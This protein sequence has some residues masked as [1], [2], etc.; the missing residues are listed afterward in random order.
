VFAKEIDL[1]MKSSAA[2]LV[3]VFCVAAISLQAQTPPPATQEPD[4]EVLRAA[5]AN[6]CHFVSLEM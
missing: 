1:P 4:Y 2:T 5:A 3:L 6:V